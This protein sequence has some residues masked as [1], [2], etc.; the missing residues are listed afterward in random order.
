MSHNSSARKAAPHAHG[1]LW[2]RAKALHGP[3]ERARAPPRAGRRP[4]SGARWRAVGAA[5]PRR[6]GRGARRG[7]WLRVGHA[8]VPKSYAAGCTEFLCSAPSCDGRCLHK[9][10]DPLPRVLY[11]A[12]IL[13]PATRDRVRSTDHGARNTARTTSVSRCVAPP[14]AI[15]GVGVIAV[16]RSRRRMSSPV[17]AA[18]PSPVPHVGCAS[19]P[20]NDRGVGGAALEAASALSTRCTSACSTLPQPEPQPGDRLR[21]GRACTSA[22]R[23]NA[24]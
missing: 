2:R 11:S 14:Q 10:T 8:T 17:A 13:P 7:V 16:T 18:G 3:P 22:T 9:A 6:R 1:V 20:G 5:R 19:S 12:P 23:G 15:A 4:A 21:A 24:V